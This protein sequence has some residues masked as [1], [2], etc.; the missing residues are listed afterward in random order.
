[1]ILV[2]FSALAKDVRVGFVANPTYCGVS[3]DEVLS[4]G[5]GCLLIEADTGKILL[6]T[7]QA[8]ESVDCRT[9]VE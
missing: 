6:Q 2:G 4:S 5:F 3:G 1:M 9:V 7:F 8:G